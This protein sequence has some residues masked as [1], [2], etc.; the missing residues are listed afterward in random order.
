MIKGEVLFVSLNTEDVTL[1]KAKRDVKERELVSGELAKIREEKRAA[2]LAEI[3]AAYDAIGGLTAKTLRSC[4]GALLSMVKNVRGDDAL[5]PADVCLSE[6]TDKLVRDYQDVQRRKYELAAGENAKAQR[7]ARDRADRTTKSMVNQAQSVFASRRQL[8]ERY[9]EKGLVVPDCV[10]KF[11][12]AH[13][14]GSNA[15]KVYFPPADTVVAATFRDIEELKETDQP[16]YEL[17]WAALA[18]GG[19]RN[20]VVDL[21]VAHFME[22]NQQLWVNGGLGKDGR[23][24]QIPVIN[25]P[26]H[27]MST[28]VPAEV[29]KAMIARRQGQGEEYLFSGTPHDRHDLLP[30]RLNTWLEAH[31]WCDE[32]K[33]HALRAYIGSYLFRQNP[34]LAQRY[35]RHKS[36]RTTED[37]YTHFLAL[38]GVTTFQVVQPVQTGGQPAPAPSV[39]QA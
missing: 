18:T 30:R 34:R 15:T 5:K 21:K 11:R 32:K 28:T 33:M 19:R 10:I 12:D 38:E 4:K 27:A 31:G 25:W 39:A 20:E 26:V 8:V 35:L 22:L 2:N 16:V 9:R 13:A 36:L 1:A 17:F 14:Q 6:I 37:F 29:V 23:Q 7:E 24:I 3:F